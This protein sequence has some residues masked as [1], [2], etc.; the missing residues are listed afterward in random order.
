MC[1]L[2]LIAALVERNDAKQRC[3][4]QSAITQINQAQMLIS[5]TAVHL[6]VNLSGGENHQD[7]QFCGI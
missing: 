2:R 7:D 6:R 4:Q 1:S 5:Y 3:F